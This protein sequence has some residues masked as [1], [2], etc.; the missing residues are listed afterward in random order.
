MGRPSRIIVPS[1]LNALRNRGF[2]DGY[3]GRPK[4]TEFPTDEC[5]SAYLHCYRR[6]EQK[7]QAER[8]AS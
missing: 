8:P 6:G 2:D 5:R 7:R 4:L 1:Q 3:A